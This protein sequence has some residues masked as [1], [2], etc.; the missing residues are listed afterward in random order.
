[1]AAQD[2]I[3]VSDWTFP[4]ILLVIAGVVLIAVGVPMVAGKI[5]RNRLYGYRTSRTLSDDRIWYPVNALSGIWLI[6]AGLLAFVVGLLL[7]IF[8]NRDGAAELVLIIGVPALIACLVIGIYRGW[9]L[10][11][12]IDQQIDEFDRS[13]LLEQDEGKSE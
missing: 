2:R 11:I 4:G 13:R 1:M 5:G 10:A 9:K 6:W 8:R 3:D 7:L 12:A